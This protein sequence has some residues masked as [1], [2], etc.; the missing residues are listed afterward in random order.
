MQP[1]RACQ[2]DEGAFF[3]SI[4]GRPQLQSKL[5]RCTSRPSLHLLTQ[6][7]TRRLEGRGTGRP[8]GPGSGSYST[9]SLGRQVGHV[10]QFSQE[11]HPLGRPMGEK[12]TSR[13]FGSCKRHTIAS[14]SR[15]PLLTTPAAAATLRTRCLNR[16]RRSTHRCSSHTYRPWAAAGSLW[17]RFLC[18]S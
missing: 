17:G 16:S 5:P 4:A 2:D 7:L 13:C 15:P 10:H 1:L 11:H 18:N 12:G 8:S 14:V 9:G 6:L 3:R